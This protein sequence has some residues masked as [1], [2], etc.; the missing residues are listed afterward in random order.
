MKYEEE[1]HALAAALKEGKEAAR[2]D[3]LVAALTRRLDWISKP[4]HKAWSVLHH[5][6][7]AGDVGLL[8]RVVGIPGR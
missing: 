7:H 8:D 4:H 1:A 6:V 3:A 5:I 2:E